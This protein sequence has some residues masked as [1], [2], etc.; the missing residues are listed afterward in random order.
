MST[1]HH[2][3]PAPGAG[4]LP[5]LRPTLLVFTLGAAGERARRPLLP[6]AHGQAEMEL[7]RG[8]LESA[9][10]A[11]REAGCRLRVSM[12]GAARRRA[13]L[14]ADVHHVPQEGES[15]GERLELACRAAR[16]EAEDVDHG[17][18]DAFDSPHPSAT[19]APLLVVGADVPGLAA[20]H[21]RTALAALDAD[22]DAVVLG[23]S[24]DGGFYLLA[25][26]RPL[27]GLAGLT[28]WCR[29]DT[30][31]R[32]RRS[33]R[34]TGRRVVLLEPLADLDHRK[35]LERWIA[36]PARRAPD[37]TTG[38]TSVAGLQAL[39]RSLLR[40]LAR[41]LADLRRPPTR[42]Q[43]R[44]LRPALVPVRSPRP[45]PRRR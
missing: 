17:A 33:L 26:A 34:R 23:P 38:P 37:P 16:A 25:T 44:H 30:L 6:A 13:D 35:D 19:S 39:W 40:R 31:A 20:H 45:P 22:P 11:G 32:L 2:I 8:L 3:D 4:R 28:R 10:A 24:P 42:R 21:L 7:R 41:L 14:A 1:P 18:S 36:A 29:P 27:P 12:P 5:P 15:F 43:P 9:L